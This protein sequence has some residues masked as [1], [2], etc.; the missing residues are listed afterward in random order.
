MKIKVQSLKEFSKKI[1]LV[2]QVLY[3]LILIYFNSTLI[4]FVEN[5]LFLNLISLSPLITHYLSIMLHTRVQ[6]FIKKQKL[7]LTKL[8]H[9]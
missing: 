2:Q 4:D 6:S 8:I 1:P 9:D 7:F 3:F 5:Q